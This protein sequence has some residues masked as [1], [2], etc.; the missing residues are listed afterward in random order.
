M[1]SPP[2]FGHHRDH[3][4]SF[5]LSSLPVPSFSRGGRVGVAASSPGVSRF[6]CAAAAAAA[7]AASAASAAAAD[8]LFSEEEG[9]A[10]GDSDDDDEAAAFFLF[11]LALSILCDVGGERKLFCYQKP[12]GFRQT[13]FLFFYLRP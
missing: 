8:V 7:S 5:L 3:D 9:G 2:G 6:S 11:L 12:R 4:V 1:F 10:A 13:R